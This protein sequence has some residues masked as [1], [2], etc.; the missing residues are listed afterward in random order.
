MP[1]RGGGN[2]SAPARFTRCVRSCR[3]PGAGEAHHRARCSRNSCSSPSRKRPSRGGPSRGMSLS[4]TWRRPW[5]QSSRSQRRP[6][7]HARAGNARSA[8]AYS[9]GAGAVPQPKSQRRP[10]AAKAAPIPRAAASAPAGEEQHRRS[11]ALAGF[12]WRKCGKIARSSSG[13]IAS[14]VLLSVEGNKAVI[15]F[16][17]DQATA[18][19]YCDRTHR[20]FLEE[21]PQPTRRGN[22]A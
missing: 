22:P 17:P 11:S 12:C 13:W 7:L 19:E 5:E 4:A 10:H 1:E 6:R 3:A 2:A 20:K 21:N 16:P 8:H 14:G 18:M 15:G 9:G